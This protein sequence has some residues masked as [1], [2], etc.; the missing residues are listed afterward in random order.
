MLPSLQT[1]YKGAERE[2]QKK[3]LYNYRRQVA[4]FERKRGL[5]KCRTELLLHYPKMGALQSED[6]HRITDRTKMK[7]VCKKFYTDLLVSRQT[8]P[9]LTSEVWN[10]AFR[11]KKGKALGNDAINTEFVKADGHELWEA[12]AVRFSPYLTENLK[13]Y[14]LIYLLSH[15]YKLFARAYISRLIGLLD[16]SNRRNQ[17]NFSL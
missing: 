15:I 12:L 14:R 5:K 8:L 11:M 7:E 13:N 3:N 9:V 2:S 4:P 1:Y 16:E 6:A 10:A 17:I